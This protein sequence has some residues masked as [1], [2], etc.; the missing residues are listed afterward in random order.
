ME[1][2]GAST[3]QEDNREIASGW[4]MTAGKKHDRLNCGFATQPCSQKGPKRKPKGKPNG[5]PRGKPKGKPK[6]TTR[7]GE[8]ERSEMFL[9]R[10]DLKCVCLSG[11]VSSFCPVR[12][13]GNPFTFHIAFNVAPSG[14]HSKQ[15]CLSQL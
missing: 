14:R 1:L 3:V 15:T 6:R 4:K 2:F 13:F 12:S 10:R 9:L 5:K 7:K 11:H 8:M